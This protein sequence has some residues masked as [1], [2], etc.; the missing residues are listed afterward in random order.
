MM[1]LLIHVIAGC[2]MGFR[3]GAVITQT[4]ISN[5]NLPG[6][7]LSTQKNKLEGEIIQFFKSK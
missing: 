1:D 5:L 3:P 6:L 7:L 4:V 2:G